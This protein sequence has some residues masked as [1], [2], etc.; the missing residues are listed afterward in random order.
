MDQRAHDL[1]ANLLFVRAPATDRLLVEGDPVRHDRAVADGSAPR[2]R[3]P[4]VEPVERS[5]RRTVLDDDRKILDVHRQLVGQL[6]HRL[7]DETL[8]SVIVDPEH[9]RRVP[10]ARN[11]RAKYRAVSSATA[12]RQAA[13]SSASLINFLSDLAGNAGCDH[14]V[15]VSSTP[16]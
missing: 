6:I 4:L 7:G 10:V 5:A 3:D 13:S 11:R 1:G 2:E 8:E 9:Q 12:A 16:V 14:D 15:E